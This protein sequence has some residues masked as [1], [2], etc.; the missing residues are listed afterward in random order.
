N[1]HVPVNAHAVP[2]FRAMLHPSSSC[3]SIDL[4]EEAGRRSLGSFDFV[5]RSVEW[6]P[7]ARKRSQISDPL[8]DHNSCAENHAVHR[9]ILGGEIGEPRAVFLEEIEADR[10]GG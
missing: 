1:W 7:S 9:E 3:A 2:Y 10:F 8:H 6:H 4:S 5:K